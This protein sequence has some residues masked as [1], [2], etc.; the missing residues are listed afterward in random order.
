[1]MNKIPVFEGVGLIVAAVLI[2]V[3]TN[4]SRKPP[5]RRLSFSSSNLIDGSFPQKTAVV[6]PVVNN[7][8][9]FK[10]CPS[11]E[12]MVETVEKFFYYERFRSCVVLDHKTGKWNSEKLSDA[13]IAD[14][15]FINRFVV[16]HT[17]SSEDEFF[18]VIDEIVSVDLVGGY[19][20]LP[21]WRLHR[22]ENS[23]GLSGI[24]I[25]VHHV[26]GDGMSMVGAM[27]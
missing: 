25:R 24:L 3:V 2:V 6:P 7:L 14:P 9:V 18:R 13:V 23:T 15:A 26:I 12:S 20:E 22:I 17:V 8:C 19:S 16:Q 10:K 1:M 27:R 21:P 11:V 4:L 5:K